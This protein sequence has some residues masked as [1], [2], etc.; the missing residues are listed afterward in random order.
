MKNPWQAVR[1]RTRTEPRIADVLAR[2]SLDI[3]LPTYRESRQY[4]DR[5]RKLDSALFP[6][7]LFCRLD[8]RH[9]LPLLET[10]GV[11]SVVGVVP[12]QEVEAIQTIV[13]HGQGVRPHPYLVVG[14]RVRI[15]VGAFAGVEG[16]L[17]ANKTHEILV[18]SVPL[19][20]RSIAVQIDSSWVSPA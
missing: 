13:Q 5:I 10:P 16:I 19:L 11:I 1:V 18:V 2:K 7:Y 17:V 15:H 12:D 9:P 14:N 3:F 8:M 6:G 20:Q 4:S